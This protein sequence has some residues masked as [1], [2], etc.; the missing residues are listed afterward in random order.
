MTQK[1]LITFI[2]NKIITQLCSA[3]YCDS[4]ASIAISLL[5]KKIITMYTKHTV[6]KITNLQLAT[7]NK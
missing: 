5:K 7:S 1:Q 6:N 3:K 4:A 2:N